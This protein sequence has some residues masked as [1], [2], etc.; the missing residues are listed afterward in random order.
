MAR[1]GQKLALLLWP[2]PK[3]KFGMC[4]SIRCAANEGGM[5]SC[6][7]LERSWTVRTSIGQASFR[8]LLYF[9]RGA[10]HPFGT[11]IRFEKVIEAWKRIGVEVITEK[12]IRH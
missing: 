7:Q 8:I 6:S 5:E 11:E 10:G 1:T 4:V 9:I 12:G 3:R 2:E